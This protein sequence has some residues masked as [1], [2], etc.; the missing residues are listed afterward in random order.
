MSAKEKL[1]Q[2]LEHLIN[3]EGEKASDLLHDVFVE[4]ARSIYEGLIEEDEAVEE[5]V[6]DVEEAIAGDVADDFVDDVQADSEE[7]E[8]EEVFSE[9]D[10]EDEEG[11]EMIEPEMDA[12]PE[13]GEEAVEDAFMNVEDALDELKREFAAMMGDEGEEDMDMEEPTGDEEMG[14]MVDAEEE[15][16]MSANNNQNDDEELEEDYEDLEEGHD[17]ATV[18]DP[19]NTEGADNT[20][21]PVAGANPMD[22]GGAGAVKMKDGG[23]GNHGTGGVSEDSAG[24]VNT[25]PGKADG[26]GGSAAPSAKESEGSDAKNKKSPI[27]T[28]V[29]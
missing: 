25:V 19:S 21:S 28:T 3:E 10:L 22:S 14:A 1:E 9:D 13:G 8:S 27:S 29:R 24:N 4:K 11:D 20:K 5:E 26:D 23:E 18:A 15:L 16:M 6:E 17:M 7:I 12:E 2:V